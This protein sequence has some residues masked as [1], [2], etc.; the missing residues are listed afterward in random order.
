MFD[1]IIKQIKNTSTYK[2]RNLREAVNYVERYHTLGTLLDLTQICDIKISLSV[3][4][5]LSK[6][7]NNEEFLRED[8][9]AEFIFER[10]HEMGIDCNFT[11]FRNLTKEQFAL[12]MHL[13]TIHY[14][15]ENL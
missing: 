9:Q 13:A 3:L 4:L 14:C 15:D 5:A 11:D 7:T 2:K 6:E 1:E 10:F 8:A 12:C